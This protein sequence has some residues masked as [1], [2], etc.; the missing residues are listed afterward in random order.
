MVAATALWIVAWITF[1]TVGLNGYVLGRYV[2]RTHP[3]V[4][5]AAAVSLPANIAALRWRK[6]PSG[7]CGLFFTVKGAEQEWRE[8]VF[9]KCGAERMLQ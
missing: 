1:G 7:D 3:R 9:K 8:I 5:I 6:L 2:N 4:K